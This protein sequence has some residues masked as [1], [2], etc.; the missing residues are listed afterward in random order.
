[1]QL[2][3]EIAKE[4]LPGCSSVDDLWTQL[5]EAQR[6]ISKADLAQNVNSALLKAVA[7]IVETEVPEYL[8]M[9]MAEKEY[10][11]RLL[12][13]QSSVSILSTLVLSPF[14]LDQKASYV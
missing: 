8:V 13:Y 3:D 14:S 5:I 11:Q 10:Q 2:S 7:D 9:D 4:I 6:S 1:M 12:Q